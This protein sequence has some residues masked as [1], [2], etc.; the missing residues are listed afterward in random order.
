MNLCVYYLKK[1]QIFFKM[2]IIVYLYK[3]IYKK[4]IESNVH[5]SLNITDFIAN[6]A[7]L[8]NNMPEDFQ[9]FLQTLK[10]LKL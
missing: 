9:L 8:I 6:M 7:I 5:N 4:I 2:N 1:V 10:R 3:N